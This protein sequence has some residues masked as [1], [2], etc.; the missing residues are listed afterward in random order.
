MGQIVFLQYSLLALHH[1]NRLNKQT[2]I[3]NIMMLKRKIKLKGNITA[4][5][6]NPSSGK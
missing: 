6:L 4:R 3:V 1:N 2:D 5:D